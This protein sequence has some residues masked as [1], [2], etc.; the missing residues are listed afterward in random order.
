MSRIKSSVLTCSRNSKKT[1]RGLLNNIINNLPVEL[2][3]PGYNYCGPGTKLTKR[4]ERGDRGINPLDEACREHDIAYSKFQDVERRNQA[5]RELA[6]AAFKRVKAPDSGFGEK[7]A[8]LGVGGTM[9]LKSKLGMGLKRRI[10]RNSTKK[11]K[12]KIGGQINLK[13]AVKKKSSSKKR[14]QRIIP[15]P[16]RGGILPFLLPLLGA[17]GAVGGGVAG[18]AKAVNDAKS[19]RQLIAEQKRHNLAMEQT[20]KGKGIY[21]GPYK[22]GSGIYLKTYKKN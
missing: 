22:K 5:D 21:L 4:L 8:A 16:K 18:I 12:K 20:T 13:F 19:N 10:N 1:G 17:L 11:K 15:T 6:E 3:I 9:K 14:K 7:L 2:H